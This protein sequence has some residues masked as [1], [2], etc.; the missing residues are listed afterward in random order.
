MRSSSYIAEQIISLIE[1]ELG[2]SLS[3]NT[4]GSKI[5]SHIDTPFAD[6]GMR[7]LHALSIVTQLNE[8]LGTRISVTSIY[9]YPT[10][11][12]LANFIAG[13]LEPKISSPI[14]N[15]LCTDIAVVGIGC[16]Y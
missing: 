5:L 8:L 7:S 14:L 9:Q 11:N 15:N 3:E 4:F 13:G 1:R 12:K 6:I 2:V 16:R 10:T